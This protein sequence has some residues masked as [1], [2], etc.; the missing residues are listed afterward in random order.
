MVVE[1][2]YA[3]SKFKGRALTPNVY[4]KMKAKIGGVI[5]NYISDKEYINTLTEQIM[6]DILKVSVE[7]LNKMKEVNN[8]KETSDNDKS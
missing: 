7:D 6:L 5:W 4:K 8:A 2:K 1:V 3:I